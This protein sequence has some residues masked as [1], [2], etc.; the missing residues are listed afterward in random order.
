MVQSK[1][2]NEKFDAF[3]AVKEA[4]E[5]VDIVPREEMQAK[6]SLSEDGNVRIRLPLPKEESDLPRPL[7]R[8]FHLVPQYR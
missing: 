2:F 8:K 5:S 1:V 7:H 3:V 6:I 4:L